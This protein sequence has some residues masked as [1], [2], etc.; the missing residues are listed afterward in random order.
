[1]WTRE[2]NKLHIRGTACYVKYIFALNMENITFF[3][4]VKYPQK[5]RKLKVVEMSSDRDCLVIRE[6]NRSGKSYYLFALHWFRRLSQRTITENQLR[7]SIECG[8]YVDVIDGYNSRIFMFHN[9]H[10]FLPCVIG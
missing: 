4:I 5:S 2:T 10:G 3:D 7:H 6:L 9:H 8:I 1:M